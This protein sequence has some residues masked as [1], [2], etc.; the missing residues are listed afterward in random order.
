MID[1]LLISFP[2]SYM[3]DL[4]VCVCVCVQVCV[5]LF[6]TGYVECVGLVSSSLSPDQ[7]RISDLDQYRQEQLF[8][9]SLQSNSTQNLTNKNFLV[10]NGLARV[11]TLTQLFFPSCGVQLGGAVCPVQVRIAPTSRVQA[12]PLCGF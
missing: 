6:H 8:A 12:V 11:L 5:S 7:T 2:I 9:R 10:T 1:G 4:Y 3:I